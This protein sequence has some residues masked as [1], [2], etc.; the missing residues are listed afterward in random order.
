M[1]TAPCLI[2]QRCGGDASVP[3]AARAIAPVERWRPAGWP[4]GVSPPKIRTNP[5]LVTWNT[6]SG[7]YTTH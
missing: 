1:R 3:S 5:H 6:E 2:A 4:G 7:T